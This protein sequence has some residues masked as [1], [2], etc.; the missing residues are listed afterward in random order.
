VPRQSLS[1]DVTMKFDPSGLCWQIKGPARAL[2]VHPEVETGA[3]A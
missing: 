1:A 2:R 3:N